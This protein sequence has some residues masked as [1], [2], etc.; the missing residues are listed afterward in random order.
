MAYRVMRGFRTKVARRSGHL[1]RWGDLETDCRHPGARGSPD[2]DPEA[3]GR[4]IPLTSAGS[5]P[6]VAVWT[7]APLTR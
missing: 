5:T 4:L 6:V 7:P 1:A 2:V 3:M